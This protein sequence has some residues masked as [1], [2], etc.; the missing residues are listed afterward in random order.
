[1]T[2]TTP[3]DADAIAR[4]AQA[5]LVLL[6]NRGLTALEAMDALTAAI[7]LLHAAEERPA[8]RQEMA[9]AAAAVADLLSASKSRS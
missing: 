1:M 8:V 4:R 6:R 5:V 7:V 2:A 9:E 3:Q